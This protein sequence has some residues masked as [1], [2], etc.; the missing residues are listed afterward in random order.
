MRNNVF[1]RTHAHRRALL[2]TLLMASA[3]AH[4]RVL[5]HT[6]TAEPAPCP[7]PACLKGSKA[8]RP[9]ALP[10]SAAHAHRRALP[11]SLVHLDHFSVPIYSTQ[12]SIRRFMNW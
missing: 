11:H 5:S 1:C 12:C 7:A 6:P 9:C 4:C 3:Y 10:C 8:V 2:Y